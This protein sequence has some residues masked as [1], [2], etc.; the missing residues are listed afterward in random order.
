M[1]APTGILSADVALASVVL[2]H[3]E[4]AAVVTDVEP[5][6]EPEPAL[7]R[8]E[9]IITSADGVYVDVESMGTRE[10]QAVSYP[11]LLTAVGRLA[12]QLETINRQLADI[13]GQ[14]DPL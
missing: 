2:G 4:M 11:E 1:A 10:A 5:E 9:A 12:A 6:P 7:E 14:E 8:V 13:T 3:V